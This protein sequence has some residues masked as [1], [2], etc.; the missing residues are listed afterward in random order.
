M[1][2]EQ[3]TISQRSLKRILFFSLL[4]IKLLIFLLCLFNFLTGSQASFQFIST[5]SVISPVFFLYLSIMVKDMNLTASE[6]PSSQLDV[7]VTYARKIGL[8]CFLYGAGMLYALWLNG[9]G[10][11]NFDW[12][13]S[14]ITSFESMFSIYIGSVI[15]FLYGRV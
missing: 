10:E 15:R 3:K 7:S 11:L 1:Q 5:I 13:L 12:F 14:S 2:I 8:L 6:D 9:K 4:S